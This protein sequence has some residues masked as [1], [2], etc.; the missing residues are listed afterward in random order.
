MISSLTS[1]TIFLPKKLQVLRA[2]NKYGGWIYACWIKK[3]VMF[4]IFRSQIDPTVCFHFLSHVDM[5]ACFGWGVYCGWFEKLYCRIR[6]SFWHWSALYVFDTRSWNIQT[7]ITDLNTLL[8]FVIINQSS[9]LIFCIACNL[10]EMLLV[11]ALF[12]V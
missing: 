6:G 4:G 1:W 10:F 11:Y 12:E 5:C 2:T 8:Y 3:Y 7:F 9:F